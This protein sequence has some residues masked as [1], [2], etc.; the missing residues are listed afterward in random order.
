METFHLIYGGLCRFCHL[1]LEIN[2]LVKHLWIYENLLSRLTSFTEV[3]TTKKVG[4][5][6]W[7]CFPVS[8]GWS[9]RTCSTVCH[10]LWSVLS[11]SM[12]ATCVCVFGH[13]ISPFCASISFTCNSRILVIDPRGLWGLKKIM[14]GKVI[15]TICSI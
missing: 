14:L 2:H 13:M 6:S 15:R 5:L 1:V 11:T 10:L 7:P 12:L 8:P 9:S 3:L 4:Y